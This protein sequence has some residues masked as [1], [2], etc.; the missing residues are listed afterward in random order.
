MFPSFSTYFKKV[1]FT[2]LPLLV[3]EEVLSQRLWLFK[4]FSCLMLISLPSQERDVNINCFIIIPRTT[5]FA[6]LYLFRKHLPKLMLQKFSEAIFIIILESFHPIELYY[7]IFLHFTDWKFANFA[8]QRSCFCLGL[9]A[10]TIISH[11]LNLII[12][13]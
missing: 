5:Q 13:N 6:S 4:I 12:I 7:Q 11:F 2:N 8:I 3:K 10:H 9:G 1:I